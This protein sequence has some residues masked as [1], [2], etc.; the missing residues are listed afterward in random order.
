ME[1]RA[2]SQQQ[3]PLGRK[4]AP[5]KLG[6]AARMRDSSSALQFCIPPS[7]NRPVRPAGHPPTG[8]ASHF[9]AQ[10]LTSMFQPA[11]LS[12][13]RF[14]WQFRGRA[15]HFY[16]IL[17]QSV[18]VCQLTQGVEICGFPRKT[19]GSPDLNFSFP[20]PQVASSTLAGGTNLTYCNSENFCAPPTANDILFPLQFVFIDDL[21]DI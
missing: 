15:G 16:S 14:P 12:I 10:N 20:K 21:I 9:P 7:S 18:A 5:R 2:T 1:S 4:E 6:E 17:M 8:I 3:R 11:G 13:L 19:T